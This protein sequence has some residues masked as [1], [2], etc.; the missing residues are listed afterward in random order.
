MEKECKFGTWLYYTNDE[1]KARWKCDQ[2]GKVCMHN[3]YYKQYCSQCGCK[4]KME[5]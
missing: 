4:M 3:P 2:C 1:G 5:A